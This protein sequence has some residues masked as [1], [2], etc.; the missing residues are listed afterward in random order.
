ML[1]ATAGVGSFVGVIGY[2]LGLGVLGV[3]QYVEWRLIWVALAVGLYNVALAF[4]AQ[5]A[6]RWVAAGDRTSA[7]PEAGRTVVN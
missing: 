1:P 3:E 5:I 7:R 2:G 6:Y 4:P